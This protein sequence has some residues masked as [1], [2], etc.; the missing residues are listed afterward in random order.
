MTPPTRAL[1]LL[2]SAFGVVA[3]LL[4]VQHFENDALIARTANRIDGGRPMTP[5]E[6][7]VRD[8]QF[9]AHQLPDQLTNDQRPM[10][11]R[12]YYRLN[13]LHPGAADVIRWGS[14][15]R[16]P[17]GSHSNVVIALLAVRGVRS[18]PLLITNDENRVIHTVV[19]ALIDGR[20]VV[21]DPTYGIVYR[22]RDGRLATRE[23]IA[24]DPALFHA[25]VKGFPSY[26]PTYDYDTVTL[27]NWYKVPVIM[28]AAKAALNAI[29]GERRADQITKPLLWLR[30][31]ASFGVL[32]LGLAL[33]C[34]TFAARTGRNRHDSRSGGPPGIG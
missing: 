21:A 5:E 19:E 1:W 16:G 2:T 9:V 32:F 7:F 34:G 3:V 14:D 26:N 10:L 6:H 23:E 11:V 30:P 8:V 17:C 28:P 22:R 31:R 18:R 27:M 20:W 13:P 29:L 15:Y 25:T 24:A 33:A 12:W 4:F